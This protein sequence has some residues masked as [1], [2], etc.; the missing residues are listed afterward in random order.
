LPP[1]DAPRWIASYSYQGQQ[2]KSLL[3]EGVKRYLSGQ[4]M[5][6]L[7]APT[8]VLEHIPNASDGRQGV[9]FDV[10]PQSA[11]MLTVL[12]EQMAEG[13]LAIDVPIFGK[14]ARIVIDEVRAGG[15]KSYVSGI[16]LLGD[17]RLTQRSD[18]TVTG[19]KLLGEKG[20]HTVTIYVAVNKVCAQVAADKQPA[21]V[22]C[23]YEGD[24]KQYGL[25]TAYPG[26]GPSRI[27]ISTRGKI[28]LLDVMQI[29]QVKKGGIASAEAPGSE[30]TAA[31]VPTGK[32]QNVQLGKPIDIL[33]DVKAVQAESAELK[34][35]RL[36]TAAL[37]RR[38][39]TMVFDYVP[40]GEY[41]LDAT[42]TRTSGKDGLIL[43]ITV[44]GHPCSVDL[45][46]FVNE[47][48]G[49]HNGLELIN[50]QRLISPSFPPSAL[51]KGAVLTNGK[52][53]RVQIFVR[54]G[55]VTVQVDGKILLDWKGNPAQLA[56]IP[57]TL[58]AA[59]QRLAVGT[60]ESTYTI[61]SLRI[62]PILG[63]GTGV[64]SAE[65]PSTAE[66]SSKPVEVTDE[67]G[68]TWLLKPLEKTDL[69]AD[70]K[71]T[72]LTGSMLTRSG[73]KGIVS[74]GRE[75]DR[76]EIDFT[77]PAEYIVDA[78][79]AR[80]SGIDGL[81]LGFVASGRP[82]GL[83]VDG[84]ANQGSLS[85]LELLKG[86]RL[87]APDR[88]GVVKGPLLTNGKPANL[89]IYVKRDAL[90][91]ELDGRRIVEW[92]TAD[93]ELDRDPNHR[94]PN[95]QKFYLGMW[96]SSY[97]VESLTVTKVEATEKSAGEKKPV[98]VKAPVPDEAAMAT[99]RA[100]LK[101]TYGDLEQ[102]G[103]KPEEKLK[104]SKEFVSVAESEKGPALRYVLLDA[105]RRLAMDGQDLR[106]AMEVAGAIEESFEGDG[107]DLQL[108]TLKLAATAT[109]PTSAW[110]TA[111]EV[112]GELT[113]SAQ[114][115]GRLEVADSA[116]QLAMEFAGHSKS[117]DF[118]KT[119]KQLRDKVASQLKEWEAVKAAEQT[120]ASKPDDP[121]ANLAVGRWNCLHLGDWDKG[122]PQLAKSSDA[123]LAAAAVAEKEDKLLP[124]ADAWSA[125]AEALSGAEKAVTL[126]HAL[127]LYQEASEKLTGLEQLKATKRVS[128]VTELLAQSA[129]ESPG[130]GL[131]P[132]SKLASDALKRGLL[133]RVYASQPPKSPTPA[134]GIIQSYNE[135]AFQRNQLARDLTYPAKRLTFAGIGYIEL[136]RDESLLFRAKN[137]IVYLDGNKVISNNPDSPVTTGPKKK[138]KNPDLVRRTI[139]KGRHALQIVPF[140]ATADGPDVSITRDSGESVIS[141]SPADL[142][143]E[144]NREVSFQGTAAKGKFSLGNR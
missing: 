102:K 56:R 69:L 144:L 110:E 108:Q 98:L 58:A 1:G 139:K 3:R 59:G 55:N 52:P 19:G 76:A 72:S 88:G 10:N 18:A 93:G 62:Y 63:E 109:L 94:S 143:T 74:A 127:E 91:A 126:R 122:I 50:G 41:L 116:S 8:L 68:K 118:K 25:S 114:E 60:W 87:N 67:S 136:D 129:S 132:R 83:I 48:R 141:Y 119:F 73:M 100:E 80:L 32:I 71:R 46:C 14:T 90:I 117:A 65:G 44:D 42:V 85:G 26:F 78:T 101:A 16:D 70:V 96:Q 77:L 30:N 130:A 39:A 86:M 79:F 43:G 38:L 140:D 75:P 37:Q 5:P 112:A 131:V 40:S 28:A 34:D 2:P 57:V 103:K 99:A 31:S 6:P 11:Y 20:P 82:V 7:N 45:E 97:H 105:A 29:K 95:Q 123:K 35:G 142:E 66:G 23:N 4:E 47:G 92:T 128:E 125:A 121:A 107:L 64:A 61:E 51:Y 21:K 120:L 104:L 124:A 137:G 22:F 36:E 135:F 24:P 27:G 111:A 89:R 113:N 15:E 9:G 17:Q 115:K 12:L 138:N 134:L 133:I 49:V 54:K 84:Y 106:A 33:R 53:A 81:V 13:G